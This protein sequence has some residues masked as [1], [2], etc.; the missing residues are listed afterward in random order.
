MGQCVS[1]KNAKIDH[2]TFFCY[3]WFNGEGQKQDLYFISNVNS[4]LKP[5]L[6]VNKNATIFEQFVDLA[7]ILTNKYNSRNDFQG[8]NKIQQYFQTYKQRFRL[9][10]SEQ[11]AID[12]S[13]KVDFMTLRIKEEFYQRG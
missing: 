6:F 13:P 8:S 5:I 2:Q 4:R 9:P 10:I 11:V 12:D 3:F 1:F 7:S